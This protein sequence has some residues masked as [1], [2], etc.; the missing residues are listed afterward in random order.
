[1]MSTATRDD[2]AG[3]AA[4]RRRQWLRAIPA[5]A[6]CRLGTLAVLGAPAPIRAGSDGQPDVIRVGVAQAGGG[7]PRTWAGSPGGVVRDRRWLDQAFAYGP[8]GA[9]RVTWTFFRGAG[10]AV[11][12]ALANRQ[13]DFAWQGDLPAVV[14]RSNGLQTRILMAS[15]VRNN[16]YVAA[17]AGSS[18]R[19]LADLVGRRVAVAAGTNA[20]LAARRILADLGM[21][22]RDLRL[23][24]LDPAV[25]PTA[26]AA[27]GVEA[28]FLGWDAFD[29]AR[30]GAAR[31]I[32]STQGRSPRLTRQAHLLAREAFID[33]WPEATQGVVD[34]FVRAAAWASDEANRTALF[35]LWAASGV[36][37]AACQA[38]FDGQSL[39]DRH[40]P[41]L[42]EFFV[43]RYNA[44]VRDAR[45]MKLIARRITVDDWFDRRFLESALQHQGLQARW[46][47]FDAGGG[48]RGL[49]S[50]GTDRMPVANG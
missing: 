10:P 45:E 32:Y 37:R 30:T 26:L 18:V 24:D 9:P 15:G 20:H 42:D 6:L 25:M 8:G 29:L 44:V 38:E 16:L 31:V 12:E 4:P 11:N 46:A 40:S 50:S 48:H 23:V 1:M 49:A 41:L 7:D 19:S 34:A 39:A 35:D 2:P 33:N 43:T 13:I 17:A 5:A 14:G 28:A 3:S 22:E 47:P 27:R 21:T 36:S